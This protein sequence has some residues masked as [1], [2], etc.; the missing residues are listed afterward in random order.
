MGVGLTPHLVFAILVQSKRIKFH[1]RA[2][3]CIVFSDTE[4]QCLSGVYGFRRCEW[5]AEMTFA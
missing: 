4:R 1:L 3:P 2:L 5:I